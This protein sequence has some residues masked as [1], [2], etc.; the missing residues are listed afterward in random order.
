MRLITGNVKL[1]P[2]VSQAKAGI[3]YTIDATRQ[4]VAVVI[5]RFLAPKVFDGPVQGNHGVGLVVLSSLQADDETAFVTTDYIVVSHTGARKTAFAH[6]VPHYC[7]VKD[8]GR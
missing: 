2:D 1:F 6:D 7:H 5:S 8:G 4:M 3:I